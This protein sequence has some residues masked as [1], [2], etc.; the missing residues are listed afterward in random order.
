[1]P[2]SASSPRPTRSSSEMPRSSRGPAVMRS[3]SRGRT[4]AIV[5]LMHSSFRP[6]YRPATGLAPETPVPPP[7][8][9][10]LEG[11]TV[12]GSATAVHV[13][14]VDPRAVAARE[15]VDD[16]AEGRGRATAAADHLAEV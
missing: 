6:A 13:D 4:S 2:A 16:G 7:C 11:G 5:R 1:M 15:G 14:E 10:A 12:A 9:G 3:P 8:A